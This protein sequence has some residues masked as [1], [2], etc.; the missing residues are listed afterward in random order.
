MRLSSSTGG[1]ASASRC[2]GRRLTRLA[3][4]HGGQAQSREECRG[5]AV[6][7]VAPPHGRHCVSNGTRER[8]YNPCAFDSHSPVKAFFAAVL[9]TM[10][11]HVVQH[12]SLSTLRL[13]MAMQSS[14]SH[15]Q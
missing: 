9:V 7:L 3:L 15:A 13:Q 6:T 10:Y 12:N 14:I 2:G 8:L 1:V 11:I 4:G 5:T